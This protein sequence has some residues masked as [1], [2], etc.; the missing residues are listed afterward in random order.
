MQSGSPLR[1]RR[2]WSGTRDRVRLARR[3]QHRT[4]TRPGDRR[5]PEF[6]FIEWRGGA[7]SIRQ[8]SL[9]IDLFNLASATTKKRRYMFVVGREHPDRFLANHRALSS[10]L[11]RNA[12]VAARFEALHGKRFK[13]VAEYADYVKDRVEIVGLR[14][15]VP[16]V[17]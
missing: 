10:V 6:K 16:A 4:R 5:I 8:N 11:S 2:S 9:F 13:T 14:E 3:R 12:A 7:E 17:A 15:I 1:F